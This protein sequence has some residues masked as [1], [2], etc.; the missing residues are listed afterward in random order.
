MTVANSSRH[1]ADAVEMPRENA[2]EAF[3]TDAVA[4]PRPGLSV[5]LVPVREETRAVESGQS[6]AEFFR[7]FGFSG[8]E[9]DGAVEAL[10]TKLDMTRIRAGQEMTVEF[11]TNGRPREIRVPMKFDRIVAV[12]RELG[13]WTAEER[14]LEFETRTV[15]KRATVESSLYGA[16]EDAGI[17][18]AIMMEAIGLFSF[19]VD[20]QRDIRQGNEITLLYESITDEA[21]NMAAPGELLYAR[22]DLESRS[23][24]AWRFERSDGSVDYYEEGGSSVRKALLKTP[25]DGGRLT[26]GFGYRMHPILG[27]TALHRGVDFAVP[28]GTPV[29]AAGDGRVI[30]SGWH[31]QYGNHVLIRHAN[32][33]DTLY[34]HFSRIAQGIVV[35]AEVTQGTVVGYVGSTGMSTGPHC[36]YEVRYYG[37]PVNPADLKFPP[38]HELDAEEA[39]LFE[40]ERQ[41]LLSAFDLTRAGLTPPDYENP[42]NRSGG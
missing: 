33:Y 3:V 13:R 22:L 15:L 27:Y 29:M 2:A 30:R 32:H 4:G 18:L 19:R 11:G 17:P 34:G 40:L 41:A 7:A 31:E 28:T 38:R 23:V 20:F 6:P 26:S 9:V 39:R 21:G 16:A 1:R 25:V 37:S 12:R 24:E 10:S 36:H 42:A 8:S 14:W 35:G 5:P